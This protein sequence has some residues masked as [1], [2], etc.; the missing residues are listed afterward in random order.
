[1]DLAKL[2]AIVQAVTASAA[3]GVSQSDLE[4]LLNYLEVDEARHFKLCAEYLELLTVSELESLADELKL[5]KAMGDSAFKK[6]RAGTKAKFI[7][8]LLNVEGF[9]YAGAVPRAL[10]Y[11]RRKY[12]F[13]SDDS[14]TANGAPT[15]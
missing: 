12:R 13:C 4:V 3:Y 8:A 11:P 5:R 9:E 14:S 2:P 7:D 6:A 1:F 10:R 15:P